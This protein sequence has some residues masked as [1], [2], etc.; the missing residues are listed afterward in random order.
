MFDG[1]RF[2]LHRMILPPGAFYH[3]MARPS[4]QHPKEAPGSLPN[5]P[6]VKNELVATLNQ[7]RSL[8]GML[9]AIFQAIHPVESN[10]ACFGNST[11]NLLI[12]ACT[13]CEAQWRGVLRAN[14]VRKE[15]LTTE[16]Y[17]RLLPA[18][19]LGEYVV[20]LQHYPW[21][22]EIAPFGHWRAERPTQSL[23][24]YNAYNAAKH[25]R[26]EAFHCA[27]LEAAVYAVAAVWVMIACQYG[28]QGMREFMDLFRYFT[29]EQVPR[30]DYSEIYTLKYDGFAAEAGP[31][32][33]PV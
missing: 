33:F 8:V 6:I 27:T 3:R 10:M 32:A 22:S 16:D 4:D 25:D 15:K 14:G 7:T 1:V 29:L 24:W 20:K 9:D 13:E 18:C 11:R 17:V 21:I 31:R 12:L 19:K 5:L 26:E 2:S 23:F 28:H 30:W